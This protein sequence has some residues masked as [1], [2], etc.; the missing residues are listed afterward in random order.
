M[1]CTRASLCLTAA[2]AL[3]VVTANASAA[4]VQVTV[5]GTVE[6]NQINPPPLGD[7]NVGDDVSMTFLVD[8]GTFVNS[9]SFPTRGYEINQSSFT[10][11]LGSA[12]VGLQNPF[13]AGQRPYFVIRNND[14]GVD[15]FIVSRNIE[16]IVVVPLS[17]T[18][19]FGQFAQAFYVTYGPALLSSLDIVDAEGTYD[20]TGLTVFTWTID[21]GPAQP[22]GVLFETLTIDACTSDVNE[23]ATTGFADLTEVLLDWGPCAAPPAACPS[24]V[25]G[26]GNVGFSDLTNVLLGWGACFES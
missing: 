2:A 26:N 20:F 3:A 13:P 18:G 1:T 10:L 9:P 22:L 21:D 7:A 12:T 5:T 24:D 23:D 14:P 6:W 11:T 4:L 8:S 16:D 15:G 25:D 19:V 17:Q